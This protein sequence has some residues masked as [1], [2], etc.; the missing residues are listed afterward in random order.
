MIGT[1]QWIVSYNGDINNNGVASVNGSEP[2]NV[3]DPATVQ[4]LVRLGFHFQPTRIVLTFSAALDPASASNLAN[5]QLVTM[6]PHNRGV[7]APIP[8]K[9][10]IYNPITRTV[11]LQP[12]TFIT[13]IP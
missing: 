9:A 6:Y 13:R 7:S 1:Y 10:A 12:Y 4:N 5:Y 8:I 3:Y 2:V 11:K